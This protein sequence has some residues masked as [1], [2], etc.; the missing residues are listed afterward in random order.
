MSDEGLTI[1][2]LRYTI[3]AQEH[4]ELDQQPGSALRGALFHA[5][6]RRFCALP[7]EPACASCPVVSNCPVATLVAPL[8][9]ENHRGRD[10]PRPYV[11]RPPL[12]AA[13]GDGLIIQPGESFTF[14]LLLFGPVA[15]L[16]P[17]VAL[18][19]QVMESEGLGR[20]EK[21]MGIEENSRLLRS[22]L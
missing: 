19:G 11:I 16:F 8:R 1:H 4:M 21:T 3:T 14:D 12:R 13:T 9:D 2:H 6:L 5:L 15:K 18:A 22:F 10:V 7:Q 20:P 17:Y